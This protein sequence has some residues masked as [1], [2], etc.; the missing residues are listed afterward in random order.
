[1]PIRDG[2]IPRF[3]VLFLLLPFAVVVLNT[4]PGIN[5]QEEISGQAILSEGEIELSWNIEGQNS[6]WTMRGKTEGWIS[7]GF[8][9]TVAMKDADMAI[10]WVEND[11][12]YLLDCYSTGKTGPHPPDTTLNG[13]D[14]LTLID[15]FE[16]GGWTTMIFSRPLAT[17]DTRTDRVIDVEEEITIIW[18]LGPSDDWRTDHGRGGMR[19]GTFTLDFRTGDIEE[20]KVS[21]IWPIHAFLMIT[22]LILMIDSV[23]VARFLKKRWKRFLMVHK[24]SGW[25][26]VVFGILGISTAFYMISESGRSHF[27]FLH[28]LLGSIS[29]ITL[30]AS[31]I[32]GHLHFKLIRKTRKLR[33]VHIVVGSLVVLLWILTIFSGLNIA[34]VI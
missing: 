19:R 12:P 26:G 8:Q 22:S 15:G 18:A 27:S 3:A 10:G 11:Q 21:D 23:L 32:L 4:A 5:A 20:K 1:M 13:T 9:P 2:I 34:G 25:L 17:G 7:L 6:T 28:A 30:V 31:P 24:Y 14:D 29:V 16:S 33:M